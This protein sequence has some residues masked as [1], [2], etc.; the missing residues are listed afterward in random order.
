MDMETLGFF[1]RSSKIFVHSAD[2]ERRCRVAGYAWSSGLPVVA[3]SCVGSLLP[4]HSRK[5]PYFY[6]VSDYAFFPDQ[7]EKAL[8][9]LEKSNSPNAALD[10]FIQDNAINKLVFCLHNYFTDLPILSE[11]YYT[12]NLD[13]RLGRSYG[14]SIGPNRIGDN[15]I[16]FLDYLIN[17]RNNFNPTIKLLDDPEKAIANIVEVKLENQNMIG[18]SNVKNLKLS[19]KDILSKLSKL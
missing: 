15:F 10:E 2:D 14:A 11:N 18:Q 3:M 12:K 8:N 17:Q 13:L 16:G 7:I 1:Y 4:S 6:S 9:E 5:E 19:F